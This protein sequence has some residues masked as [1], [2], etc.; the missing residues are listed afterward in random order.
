MIRRVMNWAV[1][2]VLLL[3]A[4]SGEDAA[5]EGDPPILSGPDSMPKQIATIALT[6]TA[7]PVMQGG[8]MVDISQPT[9]TPGP[10]LPTPTKT[11]YVGIFLGEPTAE[12]GE[13]G[14]NA[15][16]TL[17]PYMITTGITGPVIGG[18]VS[19]AGG[20]CATPVAA[21]FAAVYNNNPTV[22]ERLGCP[23]SG[24]AS[25]QMVTQ[26]FERGH[27]FWRD[28]RQIYALALSG[29]FW[30]MTDTW[31]EGMPDSDPAYSPPAGLLQP[32]RGFGLVW[33]NS[34]QVRDALGWGTLPE[35][36]YSSTWQD[37]ERGAMFVGNNGHAYAI[38]PAEG[39]HSGPLS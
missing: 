21:P 4:C 6:A 39:Q 3:A 35:A 30:Q 16:P 7:T 31:Q 23:V 17:A 25:I 15:I 27:M 10:P 11:P 2:T 1:L 33:R 14:E 26:P 9:P 24:G 34:P 36:P 19:S 28:S 8:E 12:G 29:Q 38:Y 13:A 20:A 22:Q 5:P 18:V 37:F 32:V